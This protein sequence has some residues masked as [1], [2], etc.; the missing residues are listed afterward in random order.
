MRS[1]FTPARAWE[2]L[3]DREWDA[4]AP[5]FFQTRTGR[6]LRDPRGRLDAI[7]RLVTSRRPWREA[8][9]GPHEAGAV[10]RHFRR[11]AH[12]G[13]WERLFDLAAE[14]EAP[15]VWRHLRSW[16]FAAFRRAYRMLPLS[17]VLRAKRLRLWSALPG[18]PWLLARPALSET[19]QAFILACL[20]APRGRDRR[21]Y[22]ELARALRIAGGGP[23]PR[24]LLWPLP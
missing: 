9:Y 20:E 3:S 16:L 18:P 22:R 5:W 6:P 4:L 2:P 10:E 12:E 24:R 1:P 21:L 14:R 11:L 15:L 17:A 7:F 23:I 8:A 13:V 19:L